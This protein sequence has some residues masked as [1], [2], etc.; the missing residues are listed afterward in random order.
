MYICFYAIGTVLFLP[1]AALTIL[2]GVLFGTLF[3]TLYTVIGATTFANINA[4]HR[5]VEIGYTWVAKSAQRTAIN[6]EVKL[7]MLAHAFE[8]KNCIAVEFYTNWF[9]HQSR[10][11]IERLGAKLDGVLRNHRIGSDGVLRD[12][13]AYSIINS[14]WPAVK[15]HLHFRLSETKT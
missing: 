14:E 4:E 11:A 6:T 2:G 3:G 15:K 8:V 5:R 10:T 13:C 1:G 9:N 12:T 7:M